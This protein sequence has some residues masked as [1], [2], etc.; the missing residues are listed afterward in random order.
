MKC[1]IRFKLI[2]AFVALI[3]LTILLA[4][5]E[6]K[7]ETY[8]PV[9]YVQA[10]IPW[11]HSEQPAPIGSKAGDKIIVVPALETDD[12]SWVVEE[13]PEYARLSTE[14]DHKL[15]LQPSWQHAIYLVNPSSSEPRPGTFTT[16]MN[17]GHEAMAY[18]TYII[19]N[20]NDTIP[21]VVAFLHSHRGGFFKAWHVDTPLHDNVQAMRNLQ[22]DYVK[23][24][25]YVNLRC[26]VNPG[27]KNP[28]RISP[29][30]TGTTWREIFGNTTTPSFNPD[31][32]FPAARSGHIETDYEE[33]YDAMRMVIWTP[34]CAQFAVTKEQIYE[35]PLEDYI[36]IRQWLIDTDKNDAQSGRTMEYLWHVIFGREAVHCPDPTTCYCKVYG[37]C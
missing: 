2:L 33:T 17:K 34:C 10:L 13:L 37:R 6:D 7:C 18:L 25:G 24:Q 23:E 16:P 26:N 14:F 3:T 21:S 31:S 11:F 28:R 20:Y 1:G 5:L 22:L 12:V 30:I 8:D 29:H 9:S 19:D 35:R 4:V 36:Q 32:Q 15:T 27:C